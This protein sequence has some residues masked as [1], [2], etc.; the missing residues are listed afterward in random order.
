M[1]GKRNLK[2]P[3]DSKTYSAATKQTADNCHL[4]RTV[5]QQL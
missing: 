1:Q 4:S 3:T 2:S 5:D